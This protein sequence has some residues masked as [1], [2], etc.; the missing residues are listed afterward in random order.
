MMIKIMSFNIYS[1]GWRDGSAVLILAAPSGPKFGS[2][3][4]YEVTHLNFPDQGDLCPLLVS[5]GTY[6]RVHQPTH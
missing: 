5:M 2:Q 3:H 4:P 1:R 6:T